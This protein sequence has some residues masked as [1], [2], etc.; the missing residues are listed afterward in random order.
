M[1]HNA[2]LPVCPADRKVPTGPH[3]LPQPRRVKTVLSSSVLLVSVPHSPA[4]EHLCVSLFLQ[5][6]P[7]RCVR[8]QFCIYEHIPV[9]PS[10]HCSHVTLEPRCLQTSPVFPPKMTNLASQVWGSQFKTHREDLATQTRAGFCQLPS[11]WHEK[12]TQTTYASVCLC[13][14]QP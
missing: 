5:I 1:D 10:G 8:C 6:R 11:G 4:G 13:I 2:E 14:K 7:T 12:V 9:L 3:S